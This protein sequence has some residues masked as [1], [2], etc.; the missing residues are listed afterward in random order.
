MYEDLSRLSPNE[1]AQR[2]LELAR[3]ARMQAA[4][5]RD[6]EATTFLEIA[7]QWELLAKE[8]AAIT[9]RLS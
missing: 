5:R 1:R 7:E 9:G 8:F 2:Y 3:V 6:G 4:A